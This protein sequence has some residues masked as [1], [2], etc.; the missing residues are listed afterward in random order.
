VTALREIGGV[1]ALRAGITNT[2][3]LAVLLEDAVALLGILLT[4]IVGGVSYLFGPRPIFDAVIAIAVG[5]LLGVMAL[6]LAALNRQL[7]I[8]TSD[9]P[10]DREAERWLKTQG[11]EAEVRSLILRNASSVMFVRADGE[12]ARSLAMGDALKRH[13]GESLGRT[14]EAV[15]WKF[16]Q[17]LG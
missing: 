12:V 7:L 13:L 6:F 5:V 8:D 16:K 10:L 3:V 4:L 11:V 15:Y 17:S 2:T 9:Q 14:P 1:K